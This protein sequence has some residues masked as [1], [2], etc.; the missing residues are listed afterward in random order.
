VVPL[1][2]IFLCT[3][4]EL[5]QAQDGAFLRV[6]TINGEDGTPMTGA[7]VTLA[8]PRS[9][10]PPEM[11]CVTDRD[12]LCEIRNIQAAIELELAVS[13]VGFQRYVE[14]IQ[15]KTGERKLVRVTL[16]P[17]VGEMD[18]LVVTRQRYLTTGEVGIQRIT[19]EQISRTPSPVAGGDLASFLQSVPG[20]I[21]SGDRGGDLYIRGGTPDQNLILVD[22][23][24]IIK[25]FHISNLF[26]AFPD[27][28]IQNADLY[29]GGFEP[30]YAGATSA[31][32]DVG[33]RPGNMR[34]HSVSAS[35]SPYVAGL[36]IEGP[37][38]TDR[39]SFLINSRY[40]LIDQTGSVLTGE[41]QNIQFADVL[42]RYTVQDDNITCSVTG[43]Y[44]HD[45]GEIVP[46]REVDHS[47][48]NIAAGA[49]CLAFSET[50]N[51]PIDASAGFTSYKNEEGTP[52]QRERLSI[53]N[54]IYVA[55]DF[56]NDIGRL[57]VDIG[58]GMTMKTYRLELSERFTRFV[59]LENLDVTVPVGYVFT[60]T[61]WSVGD[62]ITFYPGFTSQ[63]TLEMP[64]TFEPR[65]RIAW[66]PGGSEQSQISLAAGRYVQ[67]HSGISDERDAGTVFTV[68]Q[69]VESGDPFPSAV[70]GLIGYNQRVGDSV[71]FNLEGYA[72]RH[73]NIPVSKWNPEPRI[74]LETAL[75]DGLTFGFDF[76]IS[77]E[78]PRY[79][80]TAS[81]GWS[82]S[83]YEAVSGDLGA[84]VEEPVFS[85]SP[86]HDQRHKLNVTGGRS[87]MGFNLDARW[88]LGSGKPY[89]E[90]FGYDFSIRLPF[91]NPNTSPGT[92]RILYS[93]PYNGRMPWYHR[94]DVSISRDLEL[95]GNSRLETQLGVINAYNRRNI[96]NFDYGTLQRVDQ[97]PFFPYLS[98]RMM[99]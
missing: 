63:F 53:V 59:S 20:V 35:V 43:L 40:S 93:E 58:F 21:T 78:E 26:S 9:E 5:I 36:Q 32:L 60:A 62:N 41:D 73:F 71:S 42:G 23:M 92:A 65:M 64:L 94:L 99:F 8:E 52:E 82:L 70:H 90:I 27:N 45:S 76:R 4:L 67:M 95:K 69:P 54:Q 77:I 46:L 13:F 75:A 61:E 57:P 91:E 10:D 11:Y 15:F 98:L 16:S 37:L 74:E 68:Y 14:S 89:T 83:E 2:F 85:Y 34:E 3:G 55:M 17:A 39:S 19:S 49:R 48:T 25:P 72:K 87:Y 66:Q 30:G 12:G 79:Y 24:P 22:N 28:I 80:A 1:I 7:T 38:Q 97:S 81:Y 84:W 47:W 56:K 29:A 44:T 51:H 31:V 50:F 88:E 6:V 18:E 96:F 86:A 33:L